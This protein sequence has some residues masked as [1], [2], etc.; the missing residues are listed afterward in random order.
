MRTAIDLYDETI[1]EDPY[2]TYELLREA[3]PVFYDESRNEY[4]VTT[5]AEAAKVL[6][7]ATTFSS[8]PSG[9]ESTVVGTNGVDHRFLR[10]ALMP[11]FA[12]EQR[13]DY[14]RELR[15]NI[16]RRF[17]SVK[18]GE[19]DIVSD[20]A[21]ISSATLF[22]EMLDV[23]L[24]NPGTFADWASR[25]VRTSRKELN[26]GEDFKA[27]TADISDILAVLRATF[28]R[29]A[30]SKPKPLLLSLLNEQYTSEKLTSSQLEDVGVIFS[31]AMTETIMATTAFCGYYLATVPGAQTRLRNDP[32]LIPAF[33]D[34]VLRIE[35]PVQRR[36]RFAE[37]DT[38]IGGVKI[39][40]GSLV[41]VLIGSANRDPQQFDNPDEFIE[42]RAENPHLSFGLGPH[43]C[44]G[45]Q[46][47]KA[48][49]ASSIDELLRI[50]KHI[51]LVDDDVAKRHPTNWS[52]RGPRSLRVR[53]ERSR[54]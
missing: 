40:A 33:I 3:G 28:R 4:F 27:G 19:L 43:L 38:H 49:L 46:F 21:T 35:A 30:T 44:I 52:I 39:P 53:I 37:V 10:G 14:D 34:E 22:H 32:S 5:Y 31:L 29:S 24:I 36:P 11:A 7:D 13:A 50:T 42:T 45:R 12:R 6:V 15:G 8:A 54:D 41:T 2:P 25:I 20:F 26:P 16:H 23:R 48:T 9:F 47:G 1:R 18:N 51:E 17:R